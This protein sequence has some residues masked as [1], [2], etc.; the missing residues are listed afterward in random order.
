MRGSVLGALFML[1]LLNRTMQS[2]VKIP[3]DRPHQNVVA[4]DATLDKEEPETVTAVHEAIRKKRSAYRYPDTWTD[5]TMVYE[6]DGRL[7]KQDRE[8]IKR[9]MEYISSRT[10]INF[11]EDPYAKARVY[12]T[13]EGECL[14]DAGM[15][16]VLQNISLSGNCLN[17][18]G[19]MH[20][21]FHAL[22]MAHMHERPDRNKYIRVDYSAVT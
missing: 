7:E 10:C 11:R 13:I 5:N 19:V 4:I 14:S 8:I 1:V 20:E 9:A 2:D 18:A 12:I 21:I 22:G 15:L 17:T 16:G 3:L 6:L